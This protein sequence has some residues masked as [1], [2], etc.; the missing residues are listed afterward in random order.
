[1]YA[2]F[3]CGAVGY[4]WTYELRFV[5]KNKKLA[6]SY[7]IELGYIIQKVEVKK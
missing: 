2:V 6:Y 5:T 1:M 7:P 3:W 4:G